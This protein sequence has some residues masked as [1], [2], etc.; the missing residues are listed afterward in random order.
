MTCVVGIVG[1]DGSVCIA[2]DSAGVAGWDLTLRRDPKVVRVGD[3]VIGFTTSFRMGQLLAHAFSPPAR[4]VGQDAYAY[5]VKAFVPAVLAC[6][7]AG[8]WGGLK[9][10]KADGGD[11]LVGY[12]GRLF[13]IHSDF[14]V[15]EAARPY[16]A[17]GCGAP[18]ALG[19]LWATADD[20]QAGDLVTRCR[21]ALEAA[22]AFSAGVRG[23]VVCEVIHG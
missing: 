10:G 2:A 8:G 12:D 14:Q 1:A 3:M 19:V 16:H 9:E 4:T 21:R 6:F 11:F 18:Y 17:V 23:P 5:M 20:P 22:E 15:A 13:C 7:Q